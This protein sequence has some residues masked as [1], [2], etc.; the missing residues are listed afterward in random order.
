MS[1]T[2]PNLRFMSQAVG[3]R[4]A[5]PSRTLNEV[6]AISSQELS[7]IAVKQNALLMTLSDT[8]LPERRQ[9]I[10]LSQALL[11]FQDLQPFILPENGPFLKMHYAFLESLAAVRSSVLV[12]LSSQ[13]HAGLAVLR[14]GLELFVFHYW[15]QSHANHNANFQDIYAW[16]CGE[17]KTPPFRNVVEDVYKDLRL[18][19]TASGSTE[20]NEVYPQLCSYAHKPV[21]DECLVRIRGN[22]MA[23]PN[24]NELVYWFQLFVPTLN[25]MLDL[26]IANA[27]QALFPVD[28]YRKFGFNGPMGRLFD[29]SNHIPVREALGVKRRDTY[30]AHYGDSE[31]LR[32]LLDSFDSR[33]N[34]TDAQVMETW[35]LEPIDDAHLDFEQRIFH[36]AT[37]MKA[38]L[39]AIIV[40]VTYSSQDAE[41]FGDEYRQ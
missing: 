5:S 14:S 6:W 33:P 20:L 32:A 15:W 22:N 35:P 9:A 21:I 31:S 28:V 4:G 7:P 34:L 19:S 13:V 11:E 38:R 2:S 23:E 37:Q 8:D 3:F 26:A 17:K 39:R 36:R 18:P 40:G 27:P 1:N 41:L 12:S 24:L 25:L 30:R 10:W 16:L 29:E